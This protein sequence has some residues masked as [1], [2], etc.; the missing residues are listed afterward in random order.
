MTLSMTPNNP[1]PTSRL[2][3]LRGLVPIRPLSQ[4]EA[5]RVAE[6]QATRLLALSGIKAPAVP[7]AIIAD[8]PKIEVRRVRPWP[9]AGCSEWAKS[10]WVI[11]VNAADIPPRQ[12]L[13]AAHEFKHILDGH[14]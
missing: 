7:E 13:T 11:I 3:A 10:T 6:L 1:Y 2:A 5:L 4:L 12:R 14:F 8:M 9:T